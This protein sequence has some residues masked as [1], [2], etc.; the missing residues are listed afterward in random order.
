[1]ILKK[2][3]QALLTTF[4]ALLLVFSLIRLSPGDPVEKIL[5]PN[6]TEL[7]IQTYRKQLGLDQSFIH[8]MGD[9]FLGIL[10][11]DLGESLFKK[12]EVTTLLK[13][14]FV[15]TGIIAFLSVLLSTLIGPMLGFYS[16]LKRQKFQDGLL[17]ILSL[18]LLSFPIFSLAPVLVLIFSIWL[19]LLPVSEWGTLDHTVLP[20]LTLVLPLSA[21]LMRTTRNR[22]L[23]EIN[24]PWI[25]VLRAKGLSEN[26]VYLRVFKACF[27]TVLTIVGIQLSIVIAGTM[28]TETIFD[29]PGMGTLLLDGIQNRDYPVVQGVIIYS[30]ITYMLIY[31]VFDY[32]N[33]KIDPRLVTSYE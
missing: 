21:I 10:K 8:Q 14:R 1:M 13:E 5:G 7:E 29:I 23:E 17:R 4:L 6:A 11:G 9:Y 12:K 19:N 30:M 24:E 33:S 28:V 25:Q 3:G 26:S 27:P 2:I 22:F 15:P 20:V 31:F 18:G 16:G 32:I